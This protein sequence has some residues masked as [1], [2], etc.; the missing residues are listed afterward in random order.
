M[1]LSLRV[2]FAFVLMPFSTAFDDIYERGI[3]RA[4]DEAGIDCL[5]VDKQLF[6]GNIMDRLYGEIAR[7]DLIIAD[8]TGQNANVFYEVVYA[9]ALKK[10]MIL[11]SRDKELVFDLGH[12][13][14]IL[15]AH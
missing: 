11:L 12:D 1:Q 9:R 8:L 2:P 13:A 14:H 4:C 10:R 5:R 3:K 6:T 7:A 15:Y